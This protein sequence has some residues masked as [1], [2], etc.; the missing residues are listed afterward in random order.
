MDIEQ[1]LVEGAP[2]VMAILR[3]VQP[4]EALAI[5]KALVD[6]GIRIIEVP[7]NSPRPFESIAM[8]QSAFGN[9]ACIGA[10]TVLDAA[11]VDA[12]ANTGAR[13]MVT[14]NTDAALIARGV[15]RGLS[16]VPGFVT[17]TEAFTAITAGAQRLKLFPSA[18]FSPA[19]LKAIREVLPKTIG[20]WAVGGTGAD[21]L[22]EWLDAGSEGIGVGGALYHAGDSAQS[23]SMRARE[24]V[25]IWRAWKNC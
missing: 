18:A 2:P 15:A 13:L 12:L 5:A 6:A 20:V 1:V 22:G 14:P 21:N 10:G 24:L 19:Y 16:P 23:V 8:L 7:L 9:I 17:P 3:G 11:A 25:A 4:E